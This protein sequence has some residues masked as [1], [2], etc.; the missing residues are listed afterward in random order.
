MRKEARFGNLVEQSF[1]EIWNSDNAKHARESVTDGLFKYCRLDICPYLQRNELHELTNDFCMSPTE[2]PTEIRLS[3]DKTCNLTCPSCRREVLVYTDKQKENMGV[4]YEKIKPYLKYAK[5][6][7]FGGL[8]EPFASE[9]YMKALKEFRP[10]NPDVRI[11]FETN[12]TLF[13]EAN[14]EKISHLADTK[15]HV[16]VSLDSVFE[17]TY[18]YLRRGGDFK[19]VK[20]NLSFISSLRKEGKVKEFTVVMVMQDANFREIPEFI[21]YCVDE[22]GVDKVS[23]MPVWDRGSFTEAEMFI[24]NVRNTAHPYHEEFLRIL[25]HPLVKL[26][27]V[28]MW[29]GDRMIERQHIIVA[30]VR[31]DLVRKLCELGIQGKSLSKY[32]KDRDIKK[33]CIY[34]ADIVGQT[35]ADGLSDDGITIK[36]M[37]D[38]NVRSYKE[39]ILMKL[40]DVKG[41]KDVDTV[42][43]TSCNNFNSIKDDVINRHSIDEHKL[44]NL[45]SIINELTNS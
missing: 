36:F 11:I 13:N 42:L 19:K 31:M 25:E 21:S 44:L 27:Q 5:F 45:E 35:I 38:R 32:L 10:E 40:E 43:I 28:S 8:G 18:N 6:I 29:A 16:K 12:G 3:F 39:Y 33:V 7:N 14:W 17:H 20:Q 22:L 30:G 23:L 37:I 4:M 1:L 41:F 24:K 9:F 2:T 15:L 34:G 26:P